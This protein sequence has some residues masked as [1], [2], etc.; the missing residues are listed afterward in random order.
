MNKHK[1]IYGFLLL[2]AVLLWS[3]EKQENKIYY[4]GGTAPVLTS[5]TNAVKLNP[6]PADESLVA[7]KLNWTNPDYTFTTGVSS[8]DVSYT[9]EM[10]TLGAT[11]GSSIKYTTTIAKALSRDFTVLELNSI[12]GNTMLL[13]PARQYTIQTRITSS[14][15]SNAVPLTSNN[16]SFT[17]T[18]YAPPPKVELP[19]AGTLW[20]TGDAF[21]SGWSNPLGVPYDVSQKFTKVSSTL[22]ELIVTMPGGGNYKLIQEQ[23]NWGSQYHMKT[24]SSAGGTFEKKDADPAFPG[25][26]GAGTYKITV[27]FQLGTFTVVK[28]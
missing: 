24:G 14:L 25:P 19:A 10:D 17:A 8:Q 21:T 3:C 26:S 7:L 23:G 1:K 22:Y 4:D 13:K 28:Q 6:P 5:S 9:L 18:P 16:V 15:A 12:L 2:M 20:A 11:F 27:D